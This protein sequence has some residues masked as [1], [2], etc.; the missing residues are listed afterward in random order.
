MDD[1]IQNT[2]NELR[3]PSKEESERS[4]DS[5]RFP[6]VSR[7]ET[8]G[9]SNAER[10]YNKVLDLEVAK[11][12]LRDD[13]RDPTSSVR[14]QRSQQLTTENTFG[15]HSSFGRRASQQNTN[16][17]KK[18][19]HKSKIIKYSFKK[20]KDKMHISP[21]FYSNKIFIADTKNYG[22]SLHSSFEL[23][24]SGEEELTPRRNSKEIYGYRPRSRSRS[25]SGSL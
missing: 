18:T 1:T 9:T 15:V 6:G 8:I 16:N 21:L 23:V 24:R 4:V 17:N 25:R 10:E 19:S 7:R 5:D 13:G 3:R 20:I 11:R 2:M 12:L 14:D 22:S